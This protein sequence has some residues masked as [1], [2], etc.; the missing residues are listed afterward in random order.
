MIRVLHISSGNLFGGVETFLI[1]LAQQRN[2]CSEMEPEYGLCFEG[3]LSDE[4]SATGVP[5]HMLGNVRARNPLSVRRARRRLA[6]LLR[7]R[8]F[9]CVICHNQWSQAIFGPAVNS[10][11]IP[12]VSW[13]HNSASERH[14]IDIW[15]RVAA[16]PSLV[17]CNSSFTAST[18]PR[19]F[20]EIR[21]EVIYYP[22]PRP[23]IA[24]DENERK[25]IRASLRTDNDA[26]VI[27]QVSRMQSWKGHRLHLEAL[28]MLKDLPNWICWQVGGPQRPSEITYFESLKAEAGRL[29][30]AERIRFLGQRNDVPQLLRA[31]DLFCQSNLRPEPFGIVFIEALFAALPVV[32]VASGGALEIIDDNCGFLTPPEA[33]A[34]AAA[35]RVL[36]QDNVLRAALGSA[37]PRRAQMLCDV[38][39]QINKLAEILSS[40]VRPRG[41]GR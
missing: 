1:S 37:G 7:E 9:D 4:L 10:A 36:I 21:T 16:R 41:K 38:K 2:L 15:A 13:F 39:T 32:A 27:I 17:I 14:L 26:T 5:L 19:S 31:A 29:G 25:L 34:I 35:E 6:K 22:V 8:E 33:E 28:S 12:L 3:R 40:S 18:L 23:V 24:P 20:S 30:I 11:D